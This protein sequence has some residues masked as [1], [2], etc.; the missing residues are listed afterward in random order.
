MRA[1]YPFLIAIVALWAVPRN[2]Q[3]QHLYVTDRRGVGL[4]VV[5]EFDASTGSA[6][7]ADFI[8]ALDSPSGIAVSNDI[9]FVTDVGRFNGR[10]GKY[11]ATTGKAINAKLIT[12]LEFPSGLALL[13]NTLFVTNSLSSGFV[14]EYD[15]TTGAAISARFITG[16]SAPIGIAVKSAKIARQI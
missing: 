14:A 10:I 2:A 16:L 11:D 15:A 7:N 13:G 3:G 6:I 1:F 9:V 5:S 8:G 12:G 4:G